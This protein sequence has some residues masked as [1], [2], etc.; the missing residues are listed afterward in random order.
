LYTTTFPRLYLVTDRHRT[1][2]RPLL[3][4]V[5]AALKG[6]ADAVQMREKD[7]PVREQIDLA[8]A[9]LDRCRQHQAYLLI[10]DRVDVALA[11]GADGVHLPTDSFEPQQAR[12]LLGSSAIIGVSTHSLAAARTAAAAGADFVVFG[13]VYDTPSKIAY[14]PPLGTEAIATVAATLGIPVVAIGGVTAQRAKEVREHGAA[15]VAVVRAILEAPDPRA[16]AAT[17]R[18]GQHRSRHCAARQS[19]PVGSTTRK[20]V[21]DS[22]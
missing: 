11:V 21:I 5:E 17:L 13:P 18:C 7:L 2:G 20:R 14:G 8:R 15:G 22:D 12:D 16:A 4:V 9:L 3:A 6:G 19:L 1:A 10:N